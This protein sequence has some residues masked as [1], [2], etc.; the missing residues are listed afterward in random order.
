[1][2]RKAGMRG[3]MKKQLKMIALFAIG[4]I[5]IAIVIIGL[6]YARTRK[7]NL[8]TPVV[9]MAI[10]NGNT[11]EVILIMDQ[12]V[13]EKTVSEIN[14]VELKRMGRERFTSTGWSCAIDL[15]YSDE[16]KPSYSLMLRKDTISTGKYI[17]GEDARIE[18]LRNELLELMTKQ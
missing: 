2:R 13:L 14:A 5:I 8:P 12:R 4:V 17:Y 18:E 1:M 3:Y 7:L 16:E 6:E 10:R 11:G 9:K 15:Y